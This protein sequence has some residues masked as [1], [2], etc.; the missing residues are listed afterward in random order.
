ML[1]DLSC[2]FAF[3]AEFKHAFSKWTWVHFFLRGL[4]ICIFI[5]AGISEKNK[6]LVHKHFPR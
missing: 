1:L 6:F 3:T 4:E 2:G 5:E